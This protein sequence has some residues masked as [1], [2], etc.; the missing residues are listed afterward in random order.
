MTLRPTQRCS[1]TICFRL[2]LGMSSLS[3]LSA[4]SAHDLVGADNV[5]AP[6]HHLSPPHMLCA[7]LRSLAS[8]VNRRRSAV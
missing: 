2:V 7:A 3:K 1:P 6:Q 5:G 8:A 4:G